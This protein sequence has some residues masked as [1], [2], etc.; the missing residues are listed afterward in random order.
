MDSTGGE[1]DVRWSVVTLENG[2]ARSG[3]D[4]RNRSPS[5]RDR[6]ARPM[7]TQPDSAKAALDR[8][9]IPQD[10]LDRLPGITP[11]SSLIV[12]DE[13]PS[14]ETSKGTDFVVLL[15]DQPEGGIKFRRRAPADE[16]G[17]ARPRARPPYWGSPFTGRFSTW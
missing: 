15:S 8:I 14:S 5:G 11:R 10:V 9:V 16:F 12:T 2:D 4:R 17:Y 7:P 6:D 3:V 1:H 13:A